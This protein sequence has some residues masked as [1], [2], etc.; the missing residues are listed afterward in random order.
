MK[1]E[2]SMQSSRPNPS[3]A[4]ACL[5]WPVE[6]VFSA[7]KV[8][9][10]QHRCSMCKNTHLTLAIPCDWFWLNFLLP[11]PDQTEGIS[12]SASLRRPAAWYGGCCMSLQKQKG[13]SISSWWQEGGK[14]VYHIVLWLRCSHAY[15]RFNSFLGKN[16]PSALTNMRISGYQGCALCLSCK[17]RASARARS[18]ITR[19]F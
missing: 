11:A 14:R 5:T 4:E 2:C 8:V 3:R 9:H 16:L 18:S 15:S 6:L 10:F 13:P 17:K 12:R 19:F 1:S 7:G